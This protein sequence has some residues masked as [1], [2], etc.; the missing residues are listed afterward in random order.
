M[1]NHNTSL[2]KKTYEKGYDFIKTK[3]NH[4][5]QAYQ[6]KVR[7]KKYFFENLQKF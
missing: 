7:V 6:I 3:S 2:C 4:N 1:Q 5:I